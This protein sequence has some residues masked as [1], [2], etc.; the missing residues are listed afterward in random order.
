M[1]DSDAGPEVFMVR[2][3]QDTAFMGG[4]Y[5]FPGGRVDAADT[6]G[7]ESW[8]DG[9]PHALSQLPTLDREAAVAYHVAAARELF[10]EAGVL[11]ARDAGG[12]FVSLAGID[13]HARFKAYRLD[14]HGGRTTF[15]AVVERE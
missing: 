12:R 10:E 1:R 14:V 5:V 6:D 4:A 7:S 2:R 13:E 11:L 3:H 8:C 15:R 9:V